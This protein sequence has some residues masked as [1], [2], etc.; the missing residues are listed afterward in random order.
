MIVD[1]H[2]RVWASIDDF[3]ASVAQASRRHRSAPW[4]SETATADVHAQAMGPVAYAAVLGFESG[5]LG[6]AID[7]ES[8]AAAVAT[9]PSKNVGFVGIDPMLGGAVEKLEAALAMGLVGVTLSPAAAGFHPADT[10]AMALFEACVE[11]KVPVLVDSSAA[12][13]SEARMEFA[14]PY[15][16][17]EVARAFPTLK[18]VLGGFGRPWIEEGVA[19]MF[20]HPNVYA[21]VSG[22]VRHSWQLYNALVHAY[23]AGV[24]NQVLFGSGF[25]FC[26]PEEA[27]KTLYSVNAISQGTPLPGVP[28]D[29][30][31][32]VVERDTLAELGIAR[33]DPKKDEAQSADVKSEASSME[34]ER[35]AVSAQGESQPMSRDN[36]ESNLKHAPKRDDE[37]PPETPEPATDGATS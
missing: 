23:Q 34:F 27:I 26:S 29:Q 16:F 15:L 28:R 36:A 33:P 1:L 35:V 37:D 18:L 6:A 9:S 5:L 8:V 3:G 30:L 21:D 20:K 4:A 2:T 7:A 12:L 13:C 22:L 25:P 10:R 31:R 14:R 11:H 17:D 19:M 24:M 32:I